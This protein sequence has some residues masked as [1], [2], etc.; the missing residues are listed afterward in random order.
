MT[1][2]IFKYAT[3]TPEFGLQFNSAPHTVHA[4]NHV[5]TLNEKQHEEL[6]ELLPHRSDIAQNLRRIDIDAA[7]KMAREHL[8]KQ[9]PQA[10]QGPRHSQAGVKDDPNIKPIEV[11]TPPEAGNNLAARLKGNRESLLAPNQEQD[12][13]P[14]HVIEED[15]VHNDDL[16]NAPP[17]NAIK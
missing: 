13:V 7:E 11:K 5:L 9:R 12:R 8:G 16:E 1:N 3:T 10:H 15:A 2:Q 4:V 6:L 14:F 17:P